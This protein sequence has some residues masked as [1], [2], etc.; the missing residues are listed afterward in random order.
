MNFFEVHRLMPVKLGNFDPTQISIIN[1]DFPETK[2]FRQELMLLS[3]FI[4]L[5]RNVTLCLSFSKMLYTDRVYGIFA[6]VVFVV[7]LFSIAQH[8][9]DFGVIFMFKFRCVEI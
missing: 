6:Y 1:V 4:F 3:L 5:S 9:L 8:Y 2:F 7:L